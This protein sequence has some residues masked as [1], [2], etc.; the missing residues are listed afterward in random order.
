MPIKSNVKVSKLDAAKRQLETAIRLYFNDADPMSIYTLAGASHGIL[1]NLQKN[2]NV[3]HDNS[4]QIDNLVIRDKYKKE[5][6]KAIKESRKS[7]QMT[8]KDEKALINFN[9]RINELFLFD[10]VEKYI[11]LTSEQVPY[12]IIFR[13]WFVYKHQSMFRLPNGRNL[14][15]NNLMKHYKDNKAEYFSTML[16]ASSGLP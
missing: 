9:P 15:I 2:L 13:G 4:G 8:S 10:A 5:I 14:V 3:R 16:S 12:F 11:N 1:E 6:Q 7:F